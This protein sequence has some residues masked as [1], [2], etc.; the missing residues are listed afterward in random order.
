MNFPQKDLSL[1]HISQSYQGLLQTHGEYVLDGLGNT[2][3]RVGPTG[4][5]GEP[6]SLVRSDATAS[7]VVASA[8]YAGTA[9]FAEVA[10]TASVA[11]LAQ[12]AYNALTA[13]HFDSVI[14]SASF[15]VSAS[16]SETASYVHTAATASYLFGSIESAS[17]SSY[18]VTASHVDGYVKKTGDT[19]TGD[20]IGTDFVK[21]RSG[22]ITRDGDGNVSQVS[23][24]GGRTL[25]ITRTDGYIS[26]ITDGARIWNYTRNVNNQVT[27]WTVSL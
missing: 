19:M 25:N 20:L 24:T 11:I 16:V 15:A 14:E 6:V 26:S 3:L 12:V 18:A 1:Q 8:S 27:S 22:T 7:M 10:E 17:Y 13:S 21:T 4:S 2:I 5:F 9:I 23:L